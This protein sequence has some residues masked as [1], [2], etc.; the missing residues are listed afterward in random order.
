LR[1]DNEYKRF[2][3]IIY[4]NNI[5]GDNINPAA[6]NALINGDLGNFLTASTSGGIEAQ[7]AKGQ[8]DFVNSTTLPKEMKG[9]CTIEKL[10]SLGI[11]FH[12]E[13]DDLFVNVTLPEGWSKRATDHSMHSD[14]LDDK[15]RKRASIFYKA[16]FYDRRA[17]ISLSR[18]F[19]FGCDPEDEYKTYISYE[20]RKNGNWYGV[21][22]DCEKT[23][24]RTKPI[25]AINYDQHEEL[26]AKAK[27]WLEENYPDY[28]NELAYWD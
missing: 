17:F 24:Y 11:E 9:G 6:L 15:G 2:S 13:V 18:R 7:E 20:D 3:L 28:E 5:I 19:L 27:E 12:D 10:K 22:N 21:V 16:A 4:K 23:I 14:L 25:K 1:H 26:C 8:I